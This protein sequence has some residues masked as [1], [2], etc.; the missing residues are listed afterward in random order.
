MCGSWWHA[1]NASDH[2]P[3]F[4]EFNI[5][6][7]SAT[8]SNYEPSRLR[9]DKLDKTAIDYTYTAVLSSQLNGIEKR[10]FKKNAYVED[11]YEVIVAQVN[12]AASKCIPSTS[13]KSYLKPYWK[14]GIKAYH[15]TMFNKR[16]N[17]TF[18]Q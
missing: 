11:Y 10:E 2:L 13:F 15:K 5:S 7:V 6:Y 17:C 16:Q 8:E 18:S 4:A 9:W 1:L 12:Y 3:V 14:K